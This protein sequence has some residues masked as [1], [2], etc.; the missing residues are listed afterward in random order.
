MQVNADPH[1]EELAV[2]GQNGLPGNTQGSNQIQ[3]VNAPRLNW[4]E[5][6]TCCKC[7]EKGCLA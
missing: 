3:D 7:G 2:Q 6:L 5:N 1:S 4:K